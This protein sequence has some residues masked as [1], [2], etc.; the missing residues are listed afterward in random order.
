MGNKRLITLTDNNGKTFKAEVLLFFRMPNSSKEYV[1]YTLNET[2]DN[3][4]VI[5]ASMLVNVNNTYHLE[6]IEDK[7]E[8]SNIKNIMK[9]IITNGSS[10]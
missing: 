5:Y 9:D 1:I 7:D 2:D 6:N 10:S 3:M 4:A 8:W